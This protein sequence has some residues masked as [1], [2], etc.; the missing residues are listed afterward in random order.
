MTTRAELGF[1]RANAGE[2]PPDWGQAADIRAEFAGMLRQCNL[3]FRT[4]LVYSDRR[5]LSGKGRGRSLWSGDN[6]PLVAR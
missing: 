2:Y 5:S 1:I 4:S 6:G 3:A